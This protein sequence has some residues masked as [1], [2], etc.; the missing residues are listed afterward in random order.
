MEVEETVDDFI[1]VG[2]VVVLEVD[3]EVVVALV[4]RVVDVDEGRFIRTSSRM[5]AL[6][7][8]PVHPN[9]K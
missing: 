8:V 3:V 7:L 5:I 2:V 6:A 4:T 1:E 9:R